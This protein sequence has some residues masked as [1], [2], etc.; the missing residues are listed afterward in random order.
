MAERSAWLVIAGLLLATALFGLLLSPDTGRSPLD[1][2]PSTFRATP[3]GT[4]AL[5]LL[6]EEL[7][8]PVAQRMSPLVEG[9]PLPGAMAILSPTETPSPA[10]VEALL[11]WLE[12]GGRLLYAAMPDDTIAAALGL[13][14]EPVV[15][16]SFFAGEASAE[17]FPVAGAPFTAG[18]D[19]VPGFRFA[20]A[21]SS[22]AVA[23]G[24][25]RAVLQLP[26]GRWTA[27]II[28]VGAGTV[29]AWSDVMP[30]G[31][32]WMPEGSAPLLFARAAR[33]FAAAG[34]TIQFDEYH[35]GF[36][37]DGSPVGALVAF[38]RDTRAGR[39]TLQ[40]ALAGAGLLLLLGARF[41]APRP[42]PPARRR[43]PLEH[44]HALAAAYRAGKAE[45]RARHLVLVGLARRLGR[46]PPA[47]GEELVFL[48][49]L[50]RHLATDRG[51]ADAL[52]E[53]WHDRE[54]HDLTLLAQRADD[55]AMERAAT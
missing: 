43:S 47:A 30:L 33:E 26:D 35:H 51:A 40:L 29:M 22:A 34:G 45:N 2:R 25:A 11:Q 9:A 42:P 15:A 46:R 10:E 19:S 48:E 17:A 13:V 6:L 44:L 1:P 20:F 7:E 5:Y 4:L 3:R 50:R 41:G 55:L 28:P 21:D 54:E 53:A 24:G 38:L 36:S 52:L 23:R 39:M 32:A 16:D 12:E 31:N 18:V 14:L 37:G 49:G 8:I 27:A